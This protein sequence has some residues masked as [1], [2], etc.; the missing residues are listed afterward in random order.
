VANY[1]ANGLQIHDVKIL[2]LSG[3]AHYNVYGY[4]DRSRLPGAVLN[5]PDPNAAPAGSAPGTVGMNCT[6][7]DGNADFLGGITRVPP[8]I[9]RLPPL[10]EDSESSSQH[11]ECPLNGEA[12]FRTLRVFCVQDCYD[13]GHLERTRACRTL[14]CS[15]HHTAAAELP[16]RSCAWRRLR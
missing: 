10:K 5:T 13:R 9:L 3:G 4:D 8:E 6:N 7:P 2:G 14:T 1:E 12:F 11:S 16:L 15:D